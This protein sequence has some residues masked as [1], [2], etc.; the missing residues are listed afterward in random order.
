[1]LL[2]DPQSYQENVSENIVGANVYGTSHTV[3]RLQIVLHP[4]NETWHIG[5][6]AYGEVASDTAA[7]KG[8]AT[9]YNPGFARYHA[10]KLLLVDRRGIRVWRAETDANSE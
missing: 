10:R 6:E 2:P 4:D 1:R 8:P 7:S 5:L 3:N 9:F